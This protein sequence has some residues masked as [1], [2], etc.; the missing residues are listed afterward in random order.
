MIIFTAMLIPFITAIVLW[1]WFRHKTLWWEFL[2]PFGASFIV[3]LIIYL[4]SS[5][6]SYKKEYWTNYIN[7]IV[8]DEPWDEW[9][10]YID[11][12]SD[13]KRTK[14]VIRTRIDY[15]GP[16]YYAIDNQNN[17]YL[18]TE[19][20]FNT[21]ATKWNN[22]EFVD[23]QRKYH[24]INGNRYVSNFNGQDKD[25]W[26]KRSVHWYY[27]PIIASKSVFKFEIIKEE[28][29]KQYNIID[30]PEIDKTY[31]GPILGDTGLIT[32]EDQHLLECINARFGASSKI[33][34]WFIVFQNKSIDAASLQE[35]H[36][37]NGNMNEIVVCLGIDE[38]AKLQWS[39]TFSW[40]DNKTFISSIDN[41]LLEQLNTRLSIIKITEW[42]KE[43]IPSQWKK[44]DF[45][46]DFGYLSIETPT[47]AIILTFILTIAINISVSIFI[48]V[49]EFEE[50]EK[51]NAKNKSNFKYRL[52]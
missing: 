28:E 49:N 20:D 39:K 50:E 37:Q 25:M 16:T 14:T 32:D 9:V 8:Y 12:V 15:H 46:K 41:K 48:L 38:Q 23:L 18:I 5:A 34:I 22:K 27:N 21:F 40:T 45:K 13:G 3:G 7:Q 29:K 24:T 35:Q 30:Y 26:I 11:F 43:Q 44:K 19:E 33:K 36:W 17:K 2:I 4:I 6:S 31:K 1:I 51:N 47:W 10:V 52:I 42:L